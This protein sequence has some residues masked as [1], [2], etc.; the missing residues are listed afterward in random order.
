MLWR[1]DTIN[2]YCWHVWGALTVNGPHWVC[3]SPRQCILLGSTLHRPQCT[4]QGHCLKWTV[5]FMHFPGLRLS[6]SLVLHRGSD[7]D[8]L[9][10]FV[11]FPCLN[12]SS[13]QVLGDCTVLCGP[14]VLFTSWIP[15]A[16]SPG[17]AATTQSQ[18]C[19][20]SLLRS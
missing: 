6:G 13:D 9:F 1:R 7:P 5:H 18:M 8:G 19:H 15:A 2:K 11:P 17:C 20:V 16:Q 3:H 12:S 14:C 4:L 10:V